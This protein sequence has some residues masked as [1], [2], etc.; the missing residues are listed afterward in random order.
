MANNS[1]VEP[2]R[3]QQERHQAPDDSA[4]RGNFIPLAASL[5]RRSPSPRRD[6]APQ[7]V[8]LQLSL[9][10]SQVDRLTAAPSLSAEDEEPLLRSRR[11][12]TNPNE[13]GNMENTSTSK[14]SRSSIK[15][16]R[17]PRTPERCIDAHRFEFDT[18]SR[19]PTKGKEASF[20]ENDPTPRPER[21]ARVPGPIDT[22][23][24]QTHARL[25]AQRGGTPAPVAVRN[26]ADGSPSPVRDSEQYHSGDGSSSVYSQDSAAERYPSRVS[27]LRTQ[28]DHECKHLSLLQEYIDWRNTP[29]SSAQEHEIKGPASG[30]EL[31]CNPLSPS[32]AHGL[33]SVRK[34]SKTLIGENGWLENTS[35]P[36]EPTTPPSRKG[37]FLGNLVK[38]AK[39]MVESNHTPQ[40]KSQKSDKS[41]SKSC[42]SSRQ[43]AISLT[44][45]EQS[46]LYCELEFALAAALNDYITAELNAG[47]LEADK[48]KRISEDWQRKGRPKVVGFRYD[49]ETQLDLVRM[50]LHDF[51]FYSHVATTAGILGVVDTMRGN[52]RVLRVKTFCQPDTVIAKQ[53][54]DSQGL[55]N[56][57]GVGEER[58]VKLAEIVGFFKAGVERER[59]TTA[60]RLQRG[61][62]QH[63]Q[64]EEGTASTMTQGNL[65]NTGLGQGYGQT[66]ADDEWWGRTVAATTSQ[67]RHGSTGQDGQVAFDRM[68]PAQYE[69]QGEQGYHDE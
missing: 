11:A 24:A 27:P 6:Q 26:L 47:R 21:G 63:R 23:I 28:K 25:A 17:Y 52:A 50:H 55:F 2:T 56:I 61:H 32:L 8:Y 35:K 62:E 19:S 5:S 18:P 29:S 13:A 33:P 12:G 14:R 54:I 9:T 42:P 46:L 67:I 1:G 30:A 51:R 68:D 69:S 44:P 16:H 49:L 20:D 3:S 57:L 37:G 45:R 40:H 60:R 58:Q 7:G 66:H 22:I 53:L 41:T 31:T 39:E 36:T 4:I 43:L 38:R 59:I 64:Q 65:I 34:A 15:P 48:L 10:D